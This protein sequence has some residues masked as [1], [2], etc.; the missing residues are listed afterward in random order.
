MSGPILQALYSVPITRR[1]GSAESL[2]P[3]ECRART[4]AP[5]LTQ[6]GVAA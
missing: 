2:I 6:A 3:E 1:V 5:S 4:H